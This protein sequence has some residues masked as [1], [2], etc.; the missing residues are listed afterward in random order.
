M[1][2]SSHNAELKFPADVEDRL[3]WF[4]RSG[5]MFLRAPLREVRSHDHYG[6][7]RRCNSAHRSY[8]ALTRAGMVGGTVLILATNS[9]SAGMIDGTSATAAE[10]T[11]MRLVWRPAT[12]IK[13]QTT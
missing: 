6:R 13:A 5:E 10:L 7:L 1:V 9:V 4:R 12:I 8:T 2:Q 3:K 11:A